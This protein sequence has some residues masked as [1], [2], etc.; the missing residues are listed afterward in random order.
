MSERT[1]KILE[2]LLKAA[3]P[4]ILKEYAPD[5]CIASTAC[6]IDVL[7]Y[8]GILAE[9]LPV[10]TMLFNGPFVR[11]IEA[12]SPFPTNPE[13]LKRWGKED[14]SYSVGI[15][16]G[17]EKHKPNKW[18]GHLG[19]LA[20]KQYFLDLSVDQ[21][22]RPKHNMLFEPFCVQVETDFVLG[23][24]ACSFMYNDCLIRMEA[25]PKNLGFLSSPD[26]C[27]ADRRKAVKMRIIKK[28]EEAIHD[29]G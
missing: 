29:R 24:R 20:E 25:F 6:G 10:R 8:F 11:R 17:G 27:F 19:I 2:L 7:T 13:Q 21:G 15:G 3:R 5:S 18:A 26:W 12:G 28:I 14:G 4:E 9:P 23:K 1:L 22:S 16:F